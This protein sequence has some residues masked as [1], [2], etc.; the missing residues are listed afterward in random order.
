VLR[1]Y[2]GGTCGANGSCSYAGTDRAC[3]VGCEDGACLSLR[4]VQIAVGTGLVCVLMSNQRIYCQGMGRT[5]GNGSEAGSST[6]RLV[7]GITTAIQLT[8]RAGATCA[9]LA[10][11]TVQCW[12]SQSSGQLG[13]GPSDDNA[14]SPQAV[15]GLTNVS[16]IRTDGHATCAL[17]SN[18][19]VRCWGENSDSLTTSYPH[20]IPELGGVKHLGDGR[21]GFCTLQND[22]TVQCWRGADGTPTPVAGLAEVIQLSGSCALSGDGSVRCWGNEGL[23]VGAPDVETVILVP[24]LGKV[25]RISSGGS[26]VCAILSDK[27]LSCWGK[28]A[29]MGQIDYGPYPLPISGLGSVSEVA[30]AESSTCVIQADDVV[31]CWGDN[32]FG[33]LGEG[34]VTAFTPVTLQGLPTGD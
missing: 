17:L 15:P 8:S 12:G 21:P 9:L 2:S 14:L 7:S 19:T 24:G 18:G 5:L 10:D 22:G 3:G 29:F 1:T 23:I 30:T 4:P 6:P 11:R 26:H 20:T 34:S 27:S 16:E 13:V 31:K 32:Q 33:Q 28:D 25:T